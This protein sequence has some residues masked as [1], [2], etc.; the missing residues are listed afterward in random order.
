MPSIGSPILHLQQTFILP[1]R[2]VSSYNIFVFLCLLDRMSVEVYSEC[3]LQLPFTDGQLRTFDRCLI[4][5]RQYDIGNYALRAIDL[6]NN[7]SVRID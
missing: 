5:L 3:R 6:K 1:I 2:I 4:E 7:K